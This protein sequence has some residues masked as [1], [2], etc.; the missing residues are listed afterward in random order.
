M[1]NFKFATTIVVFLFG[2]LSNWILSKTGVEIPTEV[3][4]AFVAIII[5]FL[6]RYSRLWETKTTGYVV[7]K[8]DK[9]PNQYE[10]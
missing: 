2:L 9:T 4:T 3:Q 6:G 7:R 8:I 5:A 10:P 1:Q